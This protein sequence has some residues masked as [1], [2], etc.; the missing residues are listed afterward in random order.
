M[1]SPKQTPPSFSQYPA[2]GMRQ[3]P[4]GSSFNQSPP[5]G[6]VNSGKG[7]MGGIQGLLQRFMP[8]GASPS[9]GGVTGSL[10]GATSTGT[11]ITGMLG[12]VQQ[13]LKMAQTAGPVVQQYGPMVKNLPA[14]L[15]M[16]K[17]FNSSEDV[18]ELE[19]S[20]D[21]AI[22]DEHSEQ[23]TKNKIEI[24]KENI[25]RIETDTQKK[26]ISKKKREEDK[27]PGTSSPKLYI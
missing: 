9:V 12:N 1:F 19:E 10:T 22:D 5:M 16:I 25:N 20:T 26:E 2:Q 8:K 3:F 23:E 14:M 6:P 21:Y 24:Q 18:D 13:V 7:G 27:L 15:K 17:A 4:F 11:G